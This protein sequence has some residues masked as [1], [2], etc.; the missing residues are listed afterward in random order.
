MFAWVLLF[1]SIAL[2]L[3]VA[4]L[5]NSL[6]FEYFECKDDA[7]FTDV[8]TVLMPTF[9]REVKLVKQIIAHYEKM[10]CVHSVVVIEFDDGNKTF[11]DTTVH[12][13]NDLRLRFSAHKFPHS[14][15]PWCPQI[16]TDAVLTVDD[17]CVLQETL[18]TSL[19]SRLLQDPMALHGIEGRNIVD[20]KYTP[21]DRPSIKPGGVEVSMLLTWCALAKTTR[22]KEV[23]EEFRANYFDFAKRLNGEDIAI[24]RIFRKCVMHEFGWLTFNRKPIMN[25]QIR[26][27]TSDFSLSNKPNFLK[28]RQEVAD[29]FAAVNLHRIQ[30]NPDEFYSVSSNGHA[31]FR[32]AKHRQAITTALGIMTVFALAGVLSRKNMF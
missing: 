14:S 23:E 25:T 18:L 1:I 27:M 7:H 15:A 13:P 29:R 12:M 9:N 32:L 2:L 31:A 3:L 26:F 8:I 6:T 21:Y 4:L 30:A 20:D 19:Y 16:V 28:E 22:M 10:R 17:D 11:H 5:F 24:S